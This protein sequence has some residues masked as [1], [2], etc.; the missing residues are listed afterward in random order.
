[1]MQRL[2]PKLL[3]QDPDYK[4][5]HFNRTLDVFL[6]DPLCWFNTHLRLLTACSIV[7][8]IHQHLMVLFCIYII[9]KPVSFKIIKRPP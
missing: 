4:K 3:I 8:G 6:T 2:K 1:M 5:F 7:D 9:F